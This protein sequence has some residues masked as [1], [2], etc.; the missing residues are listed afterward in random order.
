M[1][2]DPRIQFGNAQIGGVN[3]HYAKAGAGERLVLLLHGFPEFWYSWRHQIAALSDTY[4]VVAPDLRGFNLS[5]KPASVSEYETGKIVDDINGLIRYFGHEKA[6]VIGHDWG[7]TTAWTLAM[8]HPESLWKLGSLQVPPISIWRKNQTLSQFFASWYMFFFQ[9]PALPEYL[10]G[11]N[12]F[13]MMER[14]L[15]DSAAVKIFTDEDIAEYK[16]A[17]SEAGALTSMLNYYRANIIK[18]FLSKPE[19][20]VKD[21]G[22]D[23]FYLWRAGPGGIA[24]D[25]CGGRRYNRRSLYRGAYTGKRPLGPA[26]SEGRGD[27]G[28]QEVFGGMI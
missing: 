26:G 2:I 20:P 19:D 11:M 4:T 15:R 8:R 1:T 10:M 12:D 6:A 7:A 24:A 5:D 25:R 18:R 13:A 28:D 3:L 21:P 14:S 22:P 23:A 27:G 16:R 9:I 17:W